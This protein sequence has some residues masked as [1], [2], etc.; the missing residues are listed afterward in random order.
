MSMYL[1]D[2]SGDNIAY[3]TQASESFSMNISNTSSHG[4]SQSIRGFISSENFHRTEE[5]L[6]VDVDKSDLKHLFPTSKQQHWKVNVEFDLKESYFN[7]LN[8]FVESIKDVIINRLLP[9]DFPHFP[10]HRLEE[11]YEALK[12]QMCCDDQQNALASIIGLPIGSPP[13]LVTGPFGTGKTRILALAAHYFLRYSKIRRSILVCTQQQT[14]ADAF[15]ECVLDL[16]ISIPESSYVARVTNRQTTTKKGTALQRY[17]RSCSQFE[18]DFRRK[19]PTQP[20][21]I[22]TTCQTAHKLRRILP[23]DFYFSYIFIDEVAQM[24]EAE[25][26]APLC[27]ANP[28]TKI[29]L[30]GD[31]EQV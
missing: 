3:V 2:I 10:P 27:L 23:K 12:L 20:Y 21:L 14:S 28:T 5:V 26:V 24:R 30:A 25:A 4:T 11:C 8:R 1:S 16:L 29:V 7:S 15:L 6:Y 22:V 9:S 31:K 13:I 17:I 18:D 19:S